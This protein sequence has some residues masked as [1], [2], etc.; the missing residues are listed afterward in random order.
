MP[1]TIN[2]M[3]CMGHQNVLRVFGVWPRDRRARF[4]GIRAEGAFLV[5]SELADGQVQYVM[6]R[7]ERGRPCV[8]V[9]PWPGKAVVLHRSSKQS[10]TLR[11][12]RLE[13]ATSVGAKVLLGPA[14]TSAA[15]LHS[16]LV[17]TGQRRMGG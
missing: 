7:S 13:F 6:I 11:G 4:A 17:P 15:E 16:R 9:N 14:G 5:S 12:K 8:L 1:N 3:L 2:M 10:E